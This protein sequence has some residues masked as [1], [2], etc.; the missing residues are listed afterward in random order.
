M[1]TKGYISY[2]NAQASL[3]RSFLHPG[4]R[5]ATENL[6]SLIPGPNSGSQLLELGCGLGHSAKLFLDRF[7]VSY[8]GIDSSSRMLRK[9]EKLLRSYGARARLLQCDLTS[10]ALPFQ[11]G[12]FEV[13]I[14]ESVLGILNSKAVIAECHRVLKKG[15]IL[16]VNERIWGTR[17]NEEDRKSLNAECL[18]SLGFPAASED[19]AT[20][21]EWKNLF[22]V[23]GFMVSRMQKLEMDRLEGK[24]HKMPDANHMR[25]L[26]QCLLDPLT[27]SVL[28]KDRRVARRYAHL[29]NKME[30]WL[31]IA[32]KI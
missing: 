22:E 28:I 30:A 2:Y 14:A 24:T 23:T 18:E 32:T 3:G 7:P 12:S 27:L 21:A 15:G 8:L 31:F 26:W 13:I 17:L 29:W 19:L 20:S 4:A 11:S 1:K 16:A 5:W 25:K 9:A 10:G 6:L